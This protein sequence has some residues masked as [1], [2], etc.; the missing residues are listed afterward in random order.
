M[1]P[2]AYM[3]TNPISMETTFMNWQVGNG[4]PINA[5][6]FTAVTNH[7]GKGKNLGA[8][9]QLEKELALVKSRLPTN[10]PLNMV[11]ACTSNNVDI[12]KGG[13]QEEDSSSTEIDEEE[14]KREFNYY[15]TRQAC[16]SDRGNKNK[17]GIK[18]RGQSSRNP[19]GI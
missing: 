14:E 15:M 3:G 18:V 16:N 13:T 10:H 4:C 9:S 12:D 17:G 1:L 6:T 5:S 8:I 2:V 19:S 7:N 11:K